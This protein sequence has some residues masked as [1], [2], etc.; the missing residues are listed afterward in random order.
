MKE[1]W[2][3]IPFRVYFIMQFVL[4]LGGQFLPVALSWTVLHQYHSST[5]NGL[6]LSL[7]VVPRLIVLPF[8]SVILR[9]FSPRQQVVGLFSALALIVTAWVI[10]L[11]L[12]HDALWT[13]IAGALLIG[14]VGALS[15]PMSYSVLPVVAGDKQLERANAI[16]Q[17]AIQ[18]SMALGPLVSAAILLRASLVEVLGVFAILLIASTIWGYLRIR[19]SSDTA[20]TFAFKLQVRAVGPVLWIVCASALINLLLYGPLQVGLSSWI[21]LRHWPVSLLGAIFAAF[22][23]GGAAGATLQGIL[24][25]LRSPIVTWSPAIL[26]GIGWLALRQV[27]E[28]AWAIP[29]LVFAVGIM[30]GWITT[31]MLRAIYRL[32]PATALTS[33]FSLIFFGSALSQVISLSGTGI[34]L[35][36]LGIP[37][38]MV[39]AGYGLLCVGI[40][41]FILGVT[42][43]RRGAKP[44]IR[45]E[46][47]GRA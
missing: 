5:L 19:V 29:L 31:I 26:L 22:G 42:M 25:R 24:L 46:E 44:E 4:A 45:E 38:L 12:F 37:Q 6:V 23:A 30:T 10:T 11:Y 43:E 21:D 33:V 39:T 34:M 1:L 47:P 7:L 17:V 32:V 35:S 2:K 20:A 3:N 36:R 13:L 28:T 18:A 27:L 41:S 16:Y 8:A 15:L 40:A 9:W 14:G